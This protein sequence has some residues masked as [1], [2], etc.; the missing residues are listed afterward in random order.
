[1]KSL[2][3]LGWESIDNLPLTLLDGVLGANPQRQP[4]PG[5]DSA[6]S[7]SDSSCS[8]AR[9]S[10]C[11]PIPAFSSTCCSWI[12]TIR[13]S[14][15]AIPP[16]A[17]PHPLALNKPLADGVAA[18][19]ALLEP[20]RLIADHVLDT[21]DLPPVELQ[22]CWLRS[23]RSIDRLKMQLFVLSFSYR[24][25][26][27]READLVFDMRFLDNPHWEQEPAASRAVTH[28]F[29]SICRRSLL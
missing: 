4:W 15:N 16:H 3:D 14:S 11:A 5:I 19:R 28:R 27:P 23:C 10:D 18:E 17:A 13:C 24:F 22:C 9:R 6:P 26:L 12:V 8:N 1:M 21:S 25:G 7:T 20:L 29:R 2:E